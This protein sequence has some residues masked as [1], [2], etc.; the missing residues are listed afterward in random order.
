MATPSLDYDDVPLFSSFS[1]A[2]NE[3]PYSVLS[4]RSSCSE[5]ASKPLESVEFVGTPQQ[6]WKAKLLKACRGVIHSQFFAGW[7]WM[8]VIYFIISPV[9]LL[10]Y[11]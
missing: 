4:S 10:V 6:P 2:L 3:D 9:Y 11:E 8:F 1:V 7:S 5:T